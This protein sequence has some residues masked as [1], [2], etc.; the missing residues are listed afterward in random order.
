M[1]CILCKMP[2]NHSDISCTFD[3]SWFTSMQSKIYGPFYATSSHLANL[4][5]A[6]KY[7]VGWN[8]FLVNISFSLDFRAQ[9]SLPI[10]YT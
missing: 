5:F 8:H 7:A 9:K 1:A 3:K 2:I 10:P 6:H 4:M